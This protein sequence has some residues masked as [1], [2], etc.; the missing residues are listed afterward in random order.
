MKLVF[1]SFYVKERAEESV[2]DLY[3]HDR[4]NGDKASDDV[5]EDR[6]IITD[7][8]TVGDKGENN[9]DDDDRGLFNDVSRA[10]KSPDDLVKTERRVKNEIYYDYGGDAEKE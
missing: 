4:A 2:G 9:R 7:Q 5:N 6:Y 10:G 1:R 8:K 3:A